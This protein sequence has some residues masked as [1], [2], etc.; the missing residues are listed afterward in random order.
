MGNL[1]TRCCRSNCLSGYQEQTGKGLRERQAGLL[2]GKSERPC[3]N[4]RVRGGPAGVHNVQYSTVPLLQS[5]YPPSLDSSAI[6]VYL[7]SV[8]STSLRL[9]SVTDNPRATS[10]SDERSRVV[11]CAAQ[12]VIQTNLT[13]CEI[14]SSVAISGWSTGGSGWLKREIKQPCI[15]TVMQ[16]IVPAKL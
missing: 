6:P 10:H 15:C 7:I 12:K 13:K 11:Q 1:W 4:R 14:H 8:T 9:V 16:T 2:H 3:R 5:M